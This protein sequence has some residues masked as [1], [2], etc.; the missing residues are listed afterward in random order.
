MGT[1]YWSAVTASILLAALSLYT[2]DSEG[3]VSQVAALLSL[4]FLIAGA[5]YINRSKRGSSSRAGILAGPLLIVALYL[6]YG[7]PLYLLAAL[8]LGVALL[9]NSR[10]SIVIALS[11][12]YLLGYLAVHE[13]QYIVRTIGGFILAVSIFTTAAAMYFLAKNQI[14]F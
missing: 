5:F 6:T 9:W 13:Q 2:Q 4:L 3:Y 11:S 10:Y 14:D 7:N 8:L 12:G 1:K